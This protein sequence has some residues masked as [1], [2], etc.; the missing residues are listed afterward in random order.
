MRLQEISI[1]NFSSFGEDQKID[2]THFGNEP[3]LIIGDNRDEPGANS[4]GSGKSSLMH[5]IS[6][7]LFGKLPTN[8]PVD[9]V[10]RL[11]TTM[12]QVS[13][14]V[15]D[16]SSII[17]IRRYRS[18]ERKKDRGLV[19]IDEQTSP[20]T[21]NTPTEAQE[22]LSRR[23]GFMPKTAFT[24][25]LNSAYFS[26]EA[27]TAFTSRS[28]K[29]EERMALISRFLGLDVLD[30]ARGLAR[31][32]RSTLIGTVESLRLQLEGVRIQISEMSIDS[33]Q[34]ELE[35]SRI[36]L[37]QHKDQ[38]SLLSTQ[39]EQ[40]QARDKLA[41]RHDAVL[42]ALTQLDAKYEEEGREIET[43]IETQSLSIGPM[44]DRIDALQEE[45]RKLGEE[46]V[47]TEEQIEGYLE[48]IGSEDQALSTQ[49]STLRSE[50]ANEKSSHLRL[51]EQEATSQRCPQCDEPLL[52]LSGKI[53][54]LDH[55]ALAIS[56]T[57]SEGK[58]V[59]IN[60]KLAGLQKAHLMYNEAKKKVLQERI[61]LR[62]TTKRMQEKKELSSRL[63]QQNSAIDDKKKLL[64][65][66][67]QRK[68]Q[69]LL[70]LSLQEESLKEDL[71]G[72]LDIPGTGDLIIELRHTSS[73]VAEVSDGIGRREERLKRHTENIAQE[74]SLANRLEGL[75]NEYESANFWTEGF[76]TLR[77]WRI[78]AFLP[79]FETEVNRFL[80][81]MEVGMR[82]TLDTLREKKKPKKGEDPTRAQ[83]TIQVTDSYGHTRDI[84]T[85]SMGESRRIGMAVGFALRDLTMARGTNTME[86]VLLDEVIDS[87]DT[88]G[89]EAFFRLL[90]ELTGPKFVISH[91]QELAS[92]FDHV[93]K[94]VKEDGISTIQL[95]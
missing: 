43:Q 60:S 7:A 67:E 35:A 55:E 49:M 14:R 69:E 44:V 53:R 12:G 86:F 6:W 20:S 3:V 15:E 64:T 41:M 65:S 30:A 33:F 78:D 32:S 48:E 74:A 1:S 5:A 54:R 93:I 47:Y 38:H 39:L 68:N 45:E 85:F 9:E 16:H 59:E 26:M 87:L 23:L 95:N 24:D 56:I 81:L 88:A 75:E 80:E 40:G 57:T 58:I 11:G 89:V 29:S 63:F 37:Q 46:E 77:R 90:P 72:Y 2:F 34:K 52:V 19:W 79:E 62:A 25:F 82:V 8:V 36:E 10:V 17:D 73:D 13:L 22:G 51:I 21:F 91:N 94:I 76:P 92:Q 4:N 71:D 27:M 18:N 70:T 61:L 84:E 50:L 28:G 42:S 66:I 83:F 31:T